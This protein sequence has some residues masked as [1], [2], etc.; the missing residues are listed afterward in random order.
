MDAVL[1]LM[2]RDPREDLL[3]HPFLF[4]G[5]PIHHHDMAVSQGIEL[6]N[7]RDDA[8]HI[9]FGNLRLQKRVVCL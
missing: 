3:G 7:G 2:E 5:T 4:K 9:R 6:R 8:L 1:A